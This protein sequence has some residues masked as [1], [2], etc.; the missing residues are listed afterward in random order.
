MDYALHGPLSQ[1]YIHVHK[2]TF[3]ADSL[4]AQL[5]SLCECHPEEA[6]LAIKD[7]FN[8]TSFQEGK[9]DIHHEG[10]T[11]VE[12]MTKEDML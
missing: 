3:V 6:L 9:R 11:L 5:Q 12:T 4:R 2:K 7:F 8:I 1:L 10:R